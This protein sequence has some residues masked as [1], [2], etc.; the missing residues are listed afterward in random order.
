MAPTGG[1]QVLHENYEN[2]L[3][4][5]D[6][7][8]GCYAYSFMTVNTGGSNKALRVTNR[9]GEDNRVCD[10]WAGKRHSYGYKHRAEMSSKIEDGRSVYYKQD[11]WVQERIF[12]PADWPQTMPRPFATILQV[13]PVFPGQK[14]T[15]MKL[16]LTRDQR[17]VF[18]VRNGGS[19]QLGPIQ[20]GKWVDVMIHYK[21][22]T[23]S[24]GVAQ[25]WMNGKQVVNY[26]GPTSYTN[27]DRGTYKHGIYMGGDI[28]SGKQEF[29]MY[30]DD[31][32]VWQGGT[33]PG[34]CASQ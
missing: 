12:I 11:F 9:M 15:D 7:K 8:G 28:G 33:S 2:G 17:W 34:K 31:T 4:C 13:I 10:G 21:R 14:G 20:R 5:W 32:R 27:Y 19:F 29:V 30:F 18:D 16:R 25:V 1:R 3:G 24:D 26:K 23:G 22:S 6:N